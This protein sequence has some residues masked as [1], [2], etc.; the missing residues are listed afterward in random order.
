MPK[1]R[2]VSG[3]DRI[4]PALGGRLVVAGQV[5]DV[6]ADEVF[7]FTQQSIWEAADADAQAVHD[8]ADAARNPQPQP[9]PKRAKKSASAQEVI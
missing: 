6:P 7:G 9:E 1:I 3:E 5:V 2:N 8:D 4:V